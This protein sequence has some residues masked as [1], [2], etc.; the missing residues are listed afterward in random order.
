MKWLRA[1]LAR[2]GQKARLTPDQADL[3][4]KVRFPCC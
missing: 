4:A 1:A 3:M 2:L